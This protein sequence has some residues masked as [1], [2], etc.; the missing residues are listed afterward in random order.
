MHDTIFARQGEL[1]NLQNATLVG[2]AADL[3]LDTAAFESCLSDQ[4][5][6]DKI[7]RMDQERRAVGIRLRPSFDVNGQIIQGAVPYESFAQLFDKLLAQ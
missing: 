4:S 1:W 6:I 3:G 5:T 7:A 2:F